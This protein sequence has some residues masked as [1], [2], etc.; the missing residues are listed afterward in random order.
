M[1]RSLT[2]QE[3]LVWRENWSYT[4]KEQIEAALDVLGEAD[5]YEPTSKGYVGARVAGR[6][7][8]Y[9]A[10]GYIYWNSPTWTESLDAH[11]FAGGFDTGEQDTGTWYCLSTFR[12]RDGSSGPGFDELRAPCPRCFTVPSLTGACYCD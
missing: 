1:S 4:D 8:L 2:R 6:V 5:Y 11:L 12:A 7:A 3:L 9:V 10:P